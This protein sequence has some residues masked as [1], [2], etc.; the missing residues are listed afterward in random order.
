MHERQMLGV[1]ERSGENQSFNLGPG[2]LR[3]LVEHEGRIDVGNEWIDYK[4]LNG[5]VKLDGVDIVGWGNY[6]F[7]LTDISKLKFQQRGGSEGPT[8]YHGVLHVDK[9]GD[10][11]LFWGGW[12]KGIAFVNGWSIGRYYS[13]A[14]GPQYTLYVPKGLLKAG[15]NDIVLFEYEHAEDAIEF[16]T[17]PVFT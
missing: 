2:V 7:N 12:K 10:T 16:R 4:G 3:I 15:D 13:N 11:F 14:K 5:K 1:I 9:V 17:E 6:G 8:F